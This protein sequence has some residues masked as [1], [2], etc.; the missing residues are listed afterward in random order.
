MRNGDK[1]RIAIHSNLSKTTVS[2]FFNGYSVAPYSSYKILK[3]IK[4]LNI[5]YT[6]PTKPDYLKNKAHKDRFDIYNN[7]PH[8]AMVKISR[9][10]NCNKT[11]VK[12]VL[13]GKREDHH[14]VIKEAEL[15]AA[16]HIWKTRFCKY[17]SQL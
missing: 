17:K 5:D 13:E 4:A 14:G 9:K 15:I 1:T 10:L 16:I 11:H 8:G 12:L 7:L 3:T 6:T 2:R